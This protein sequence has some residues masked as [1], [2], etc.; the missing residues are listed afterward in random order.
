M[1]RKLCTIQK[2]KSLDPIEGADKIELTKFED[3][4]WQVVVEKNLH[5][6]NDYVVYCEI[7]SAMPE[8]PEYEFLRKSCAKQYEGRT[9]FR[10]RTIKLRGVL[11]QGLCLPLSVLPPDD[12]KVGQDVTDLL[13]VVKY[14]IEQQD[15]TESNPVKSNKVFKFLMGNSIFRKTIGN[16]IL[17]MKRHPKG[18][19]PSFLTKTDEE[20]IQN[21]TRLYEE[22]KNTSGWSVSEKLD[23]QSVSHFKYNKKLLFFNKSIFGVCSRSLHLKTKDNSSHWNATIQNEIEK[24]LP[25]GF[26]IQGEIIGGKVQGNPYKI[27]GYLIYVFN[28]KNLITGEK[29]SNQQV[30]EFCI[31]YGFEHVPYITHDF[32][33]PNTIGELLK[34]A[35][36]KSVV[37]PSVE[38]E[39]IVIRKG[40]ISFKAIS[41]KFLL[42]EK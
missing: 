33:L 13:G 9:V 11:S 34:Y 8:K 24:K 41:N 3:I 25:I 31:K 37:N 26:A 23:G 35:E 5:K 36:G 16:R 7:D 32:T 19:F 39:G 10:I 27:N 2:I 15:P 40:D 20:R 29:Y 17:E 12:Y 18:G 1:D 6:I 30:E 42:A 22:C 28:V 14:D 21:L 4:A 38:R